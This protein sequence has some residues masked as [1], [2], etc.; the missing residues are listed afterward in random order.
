MMDIKNNTFKSDNMDDINITSASF[1][2]LIKNKYVYVDKTDY[3]YSLVRKEG[4]YYFLSR[5]RRFGKSLTVSTLKAIFQGKRELFKDLYIGSTDYDFKE[6]PVIHV[7]FSDLVVTRAGAFNESLLT[8]LNRIADEYNVALKETAEVKSLLK[9]LI[10]GLYHQ[11]GKVVVLVDEY[12]KPLSDN[13]NNQEEALKIRDVLRGFFEVIKASYDYVRFVFIT[14]VTKYSKVSVFS[15]MNNLF[16]LSVNKKY[17]AMLGYTQEELEHYFAEGIDEGAKRLNLSRKDYLDKIKM[18]YDGYCFAPGAKRVYNPVSIGYFFEEEGEKFSNYWAK[19]GGTELPY[20]VAKKVHFN[21]ETDIEQ[22]FNLDTIESYDIVDLA[23]TKV[24]KH[25]YNSLLFQAGYLT[26]KD[27]IDSSNVVS[28][29][30]PNEEISRSFATIL[31]PLYL[32]EKT[33]ADGAILLRDL[34]IGNVNAFLDRIKA[35]FAGVP[36]NIIGKYEYSFQTGFYCIL[37]AMG[38]KIEAEVPTNNGRI[39]AT[40]ETDNHIYIFEFKVDQSAAIAIEQIKAK[41][42]AE[43]FNTPENKGKQL[44][45]MGI[46]FSEKHRNLNEI[47]HEEYTIT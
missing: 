2:N 15:S 25:N 35:I 20:E 10:I 39:D 33:E 7:D 1:E 37:K 36:Y 31:L 11:H 9:D 47:L 16:D 40:L 12:D 14:G 17:G 38:A 8:V 27:Y 34:R 3:V 44:H 18:W 24:S 41:G 32:G 4:G 46:S 22:D 13:V 23:S 28:L 26:I 6:Y 30:F 45:L 42:Y 21:V 19:T 29:G 43:R 5:P